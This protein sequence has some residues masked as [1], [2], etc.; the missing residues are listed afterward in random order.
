MSPVITFGGLLGEATEG[1]IVCVKSE[2]LKKAYIPSFVVCISL[3]LH[4]S[5]LYIGVSMFR[6]LW[7]KTL[8]KEPV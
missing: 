1:R 6:R 2:L 8:Q 4:E 7:T 3:L 5:P